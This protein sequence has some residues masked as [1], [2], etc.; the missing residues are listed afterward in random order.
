MLVVNLNRNV[1][2]WNCWISYFTFVYIIELTRESLLLLDSCCRGRFSRFGLFLGLFLSFGSLWWWRSLLT[3]DHIVV[4]V[5]D[6]GFV[7]ALG[8]APDD[9]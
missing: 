9:Q 8:A 4:V 3:T 1:L 5:D 2:T 6:G 7:L